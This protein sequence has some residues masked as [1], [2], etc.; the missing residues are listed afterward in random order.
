MP[1]AIERID[2]E[3]ELDVTPDLSYLG[4]YTSVPTRDEVEAGKVVDRQE[5]GDW[6]R[7]E[8]QFFVAAYSAQ[9]TGN[10]DS[11]EQDYHRMEAYNRGD[12]HMVGI[13]A[14]AEIVVNDVRQTITSG[15]LWGIESDSDKEHL[16]EVGREQLTGLRSIL[17][18]LEFTE[19]EIDAALPNK[20]TV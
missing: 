14:V 11:V 1:R 3:Q 20:I 17:L 8:Y 9:E 18:E 4:R 5:E 15:G 16:A 6:H 19:G 2:I 7:G 12:W 10:P 13:R